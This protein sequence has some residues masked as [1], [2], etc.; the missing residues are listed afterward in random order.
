MEIKSLVKRY[1]EY[2]P[3]TFDAILRQYAKRAIHP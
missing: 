1:D 3:N 2:W